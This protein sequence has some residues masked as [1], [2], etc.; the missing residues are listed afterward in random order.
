MQHKITFPTIHLQNV[1]NLE[2]NKKKIISISIIIYPHIFIKYFFS[3]YLF[4][5]LIFF[6]FFH[7]NDVNYDLM[8]RAKFFIF[9]EHHLHSFILFDVY[10]SSLSLSFWFITHSFVIIIILLNKICRWRFFVATDDDWKSNENNFPNLRIQ[11]WFLQVF[12]SAGG[13]SL[14][15]LL[16]GKGKKISK[17]ITAEF[18]CEFF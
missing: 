8:P 14:W 2:L 13:F 10:Y 17:K 4:P 1:S 11:Y 15:F 3:F 7:Q 5:F 9:R 16:N 6:Y 12:T 18:S